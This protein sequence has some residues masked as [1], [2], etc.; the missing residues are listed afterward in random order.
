MKIEKIEIIRLA[1]P[2]DSGREKNGPEQQDYNAASSRVTKMETLLVAV[3]S[4]TGLCG[5]GEAFGH[6]INPVTFT[7]LESAVAPFFINRHVD[8]ITG[9][10]ALMKEAEQ[11]FHGF[12]RT[13][14]VRYALSAIDIALWDLL[15]KQ[16]QKPLW[17][18]LGGSRNHIGLYPS[19]VSYDNKPEAVARQVSQVFARGYREIK[20][21]ETT[22]EAI[23]A[24]REAVGN[25]AEI[26]VDANCPWSAEEAF[27][28]AESWAGLNLK[29]LE[30]P[31]WPPEDTD[32]LTY[33]RTAGI[34]LSAGENA[35][36][37]G[38]LYHLM[39][40]GAVD[41]IQPSVT[42]VGG[43]TAMLRVFEQAKRYP[44]TVI[45]H[46]FYYGAGMMA[47]AQ[48]VALLP[49]TT[50]L[51]VPWLQWTPQLHPFLNFQPEMV[52]PDAPGIGFTPDAQVL[53]DYRIGF[54]VCSTA[55]GE[56]HV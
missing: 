29:W 12:G 11:A 33:V 20:L 43:I 52:L 35:A 8:S 5:W 1:I 21:H 27:R 37:D 39:A 54:A 50:R 24:A 17:Q 51:E 38:D 4:D 18:I 36:G 2:F 30:E 6:L 14:P 7:A 13:G 42:K 10:A 31:V 49:E 15:G 19:L 46:C 23:A 32:A 25:Q 26:M 41:I 56:H 28:Q 34:P 3:Y 53:K 40:S 44:V 16:E 55:K 22:R 45:P 47:A 48:L 9:I